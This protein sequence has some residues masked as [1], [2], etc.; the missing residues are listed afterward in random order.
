MNKKSL[1]TIFRR[2]IRNVGTIEKG[3]IVSWIIE[4]VSWISG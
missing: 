3:M 1:V 4:E 2:S